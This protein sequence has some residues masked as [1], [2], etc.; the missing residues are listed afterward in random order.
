MTNKRI[1]NKKLI[2][3]HKNKGM[4][5]LVPCSNHPHPACWIFED[6]VPIL[7]RSDKQ[8]VVFKNKKECIKYASFLLDCNFELFNDKLSFEELK[9]N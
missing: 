1:T 5:L 4:L 3:R 8:P 7:E 6:D 9:V 2:L